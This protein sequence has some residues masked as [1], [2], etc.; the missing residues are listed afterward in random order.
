MSNHTL[1]FL[2]YRQMRTQQK[3]F[4]LEFQD[5]AACFLMAEGVAAAEDLLIAAYLKACLEQSF[6]NNAHRNTSYNMVLPR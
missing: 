4:A 1:A 2:F 6:L 3:T 5:S